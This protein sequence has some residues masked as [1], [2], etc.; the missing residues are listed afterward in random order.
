MQTLVVTGNVWNPS[1]DGADPARPRAVWIQDGRIA[2]VTPVEA[3]PQ[4]G[5]RDD[6]RV[7]PFAR[8]FIMPAFVDAHF[9]LLS[10]AYK[11]LRC[12]LADTLSAAE[13]AERMAAYT[14]AHSDDAAIVG[15]DFDESDWSDHALPTRAQ[16]DAIAA[17]RPLYARRVCCHVGVANTALLDR[18][19]SPARFIDRDSGRIVEDAVFEANRLTRPPA[20]AQIAAVDGAIAHLHA[21]GIAAIHD[22]VDPETLEVYADGLSASRRPLRI[23]AFLHVPTERFEVARDALVPLQRRGVRALGIKIFADGSLGGRTAAL[24]DR[25]A[26]GDGNGELLVDG[27]ALRSELEACALRNIACAVHAIGDRALHTVLDAMAVVKARYPQHAR[28]RIEHAEIIGDEELERC[29][30]LRI[31]L[32]MQPNFVRNWGGEDGMYAGRLGRERWAHH[33]PFASLLRAAVPFVFSSDGMPAGP[34]FGLRGA[35]HHANPHERIGAAEAYYRYTRAAGDV[36]AAWDDE[37]EEPG[38]I[39]PGARADLVV[40]SAN[41]VLADGDRARIEATFAEGAEVYRAPIENHSKL[42]R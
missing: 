4:P 33:N 42:R 29:H 15:I 38:G 39:Q 17:D 40:L 14:Q 36:F 8:G 27:E 23:D 3:A 21:L 20:A 9:H 6:I 2:Q 28:F 41:P 37:D 31:P 25:Y 30:E 35:T 19:E 34:I 22:I 11:R 32:V 24:H 1:R 10:L 26:D 7:V 13:V 16:L 12:D 18:L 5:A